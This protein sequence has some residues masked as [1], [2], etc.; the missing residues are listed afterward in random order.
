VWAAGEIHDQIFRQAITAAGDG[1]AAALM[2]IEWLQDHEDELQ[3]L[4]EEPVA[5]AGD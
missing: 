3:T 1:C 4:D 2:A 5:A